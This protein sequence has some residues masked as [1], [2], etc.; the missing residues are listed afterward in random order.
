[1]LLNSGPEVVDG[2]CGSAKIDNM[3]MS[4]NER[5]T[6]GYGLPN[7]HIKSGYRLHKDDSFTLNTQMMNMQDKEQWVWLTITY[8]FLDGP[9]PDYKD[10][11]MLWMAI[12]PI[13]IRCSG[14]APASPWGPTNLTLSQQPKSMVF[15]EHS[16]PWVVPRDGWILATGG[17]M[18][19]G[20]TT[21]QIFHNNELICTAD[22]IYSAPGE[23]G[24]KG[25]KR[26]RQ[27]PGGPQSNEEI[28]HIKKQLGCVFLD[29]RP[30]KK[31][32]T[33]YIQV[34]ASRIAATVPC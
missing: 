19:D 30:M 11:R 4:G 34:T 17:H 15:S 21:L 28:A 18:H 6:N 9:Q 10:G 13:A 27:I 12:G 5:S 20:G 3:F 24:G 2:T 25:M 7:I 32:D 16:T 29:G 33:M 14:S 31:G 22:P 1:M 8:E 23:K 26:K